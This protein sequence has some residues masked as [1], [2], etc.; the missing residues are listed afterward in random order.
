MFDRS[1][2]HGEYEIFVSGGADLAP[3]S[4]TRVYEKFA[5]R[6]PF[7]PFGNPTSV[8]PCTSFFRGSVY[9]VQPRLF[10]VCQYKR[11]MTYSDR[12]ARFYWEGMSCHSY[13]L[14]FSSLHRNINVCTNTIDTA[15]SQSLPEMC[16]PPH[17]LSLSHGHTA[18][19]KVA[20]IP[21]KENP[22]RGSRRGVRVVVCIDSLSASLTVPHEVLD[23]ARHM[24]WNKSN[25]D[26]NQWYCLRLLILGTDMH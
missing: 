9:F 25:R 23:A 19:M 10:L 7:F 20:G 14:L 11:K 4:S 6:N 24:G 13:I 18:G 1:V 12:E 26:S 17:P 5:G 8:I 15:N 21:R 2:S 16:T 3:G 22:L